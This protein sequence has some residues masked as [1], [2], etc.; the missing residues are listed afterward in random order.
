MAGEDGQ[1]LPAN[2][3]IEK[4]NVTVWN[5]KL[6]DPKYVRY[7]FGNTIIG[8]LFSMEGLPAVPFR[9]DSFPE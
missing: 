7:G 4:D 1:W 3:T 9:T 6:R 2:V 5:K 8:N